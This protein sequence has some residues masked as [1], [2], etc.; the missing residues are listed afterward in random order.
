MV[1]NNGKE[2]LNELDRSDLYN[3]ETGE[4]VFLYNDAGS[5]AVYKLDDHEVEALKKR[6]DTEEPWSAY[7]GIGGYIY[8]DPSC[9]FFN[10]NSI[11][12]VEWCDENYKG[13]WECV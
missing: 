1:F 5:I 3:A 7:L 10:S 8:D 2:M 6:M 12:N 4:Y 9:D 13:N 11:S